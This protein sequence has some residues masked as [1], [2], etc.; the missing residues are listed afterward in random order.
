MRVLLAEDSGVIRILLKQVLTKWGYE[1][2]FAEDG[3]A[4]WSI[5][6][7]ADSPRIALLDWMMPGP[8]GLEVCQ[9]VRKAAREPRVYIILLTGKDEREDVVRGLTA[10][11][12]DYLRKPFDNLELEARIRTGRR[13]VELQAELIAAREALR[14]QATT[15]ALTGIANRRTILDTLGKEL[16]RFRRAKSACA[17]VFVDLDHFKQ[18]NDTYGHP[19]GDE[20]LRQA[21][22]TLRAILRPYDLVGRYGGEEFVVVLPGCDVEGARAAA[23][24]LRAAI[25]GTAI[26][27]GGA[28]LQVTCSMG[29]AVATGANAWD[30]DR[31]LSEADAALY[32]AKREGRDRVVVAGAKDQT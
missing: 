29:V 15:D 30:R 14:A 21:A 16:D 9:R 18:V 25:A 31:L 5:L 22:S 32:R 19:A 1:I 7:R 4:A 12:D 24:R 26:T 8:D 13:I 6:E 11:A 2:V 10:G 27:A 3:D 17:V 28:R 20:V 23:E